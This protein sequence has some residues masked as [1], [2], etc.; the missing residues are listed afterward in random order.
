MLLL[1]FC[2]VGGGLL[3][4]VLDGLLLL[5]GDGGEDD[6]LLL[7]L[8][9]HCLGCLLCLSFLLGDGLLERLLLGLLLGGLLGG[10]EG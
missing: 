3:G 8:L 10:G 6:G 1:L 5:V 2:G 4:L 7:G 9:L